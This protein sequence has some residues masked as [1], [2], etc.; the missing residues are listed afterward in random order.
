M[1]PSEPLTIAPA[2]GDRVRDA[3]VL[4]FS[5]LD[6][7]DR[8]DRVD[9]LLA[10]IRPGAPTL[11]GLFEAR[12]QGKLVGAVLAQAQAGRT[13]LVWPPRL[14]AGEPSATADKLLESVAEHLRQETV[15]LAHA[16]LPSPGAADDETLR[17]AGYRPLAELLYLVSR[18][19]TFPPAEPQSGLDFEPYCEQNH[20]RLA[21]V[22][23]ATYC[24]TL[25]CPGL[26]EA[27][28]IDDVLAGYRATGD[29]SPDRWLIARHA[30]RDVGCLLLADHPDHD[31]FELVYMGITARNRGHGWGTDLARRAQWLARASGRSR[32]VLAVDAANSPA[33]RAYDSLGFE[34]WERRH[35]YSRRLDPP[36]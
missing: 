17:A 15:A 2:S 8:A 32:L 28:S 26:D 7:R 14:V 10:E 24:D 6:A 35:V 34:A 5:D 18:H 11:S 20:Q 1:V 9:A 29:F 19:E 23:E 12:R 33:L 31:N 27:R 22:V 3:L 30:G 36:E 13:A 4:V 16:M 25:D 21:R